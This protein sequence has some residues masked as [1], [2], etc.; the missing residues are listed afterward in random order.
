MIMDIMGYMRFQRGH[1]MIRE[2]GKIEA[3]NGKD[4]GEKYEIFIIIC[5]ILV[6]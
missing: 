5:R 6:P 4:S 3:L 2:D 1:Q